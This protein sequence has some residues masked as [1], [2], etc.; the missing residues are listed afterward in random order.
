MEELILRKAQI[1][2]KKLYVYLAEI[3]DV[4]R[5]LAEALDRNDQV[6]AQLLIGMRSEPI[7]GAQQTRQ[8]L[9]ALR[10]G[11]QPREALR[12]TELLNGAE[13]N[14]EQEQTLS[15]QL[16]RNE[17]LLR[18]VIALDEVVNRKVARDKSIYQ[19]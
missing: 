11:L 8:A 19:K 17:Q 3:Q 14:S 9:G 7:N 15:A 10:D 4:S 5:Q 13:P 2:A 18:Q 1:L 16:K 6:T 12:L